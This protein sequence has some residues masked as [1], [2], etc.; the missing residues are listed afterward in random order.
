MKLQIEKMV[1]G[2]AGLAYPADGAGAGKAVFVAFALPGEVVEVQLADETSGHGDAAL[3]QVIEASPDRVEAVCAHFGACGGCQYQ[4]ADYAAQLAMKAG[5][6]REMLERAGVSALPEV[7]VHAGEA[8]GY[9]NR[10]RLRVAKVEGRLRV[11]YSRR[12]GD[13]FL[14]IEECP[15]AAPVLWRAAKAFLQ[16]AETD[17]AAERWIR[18]AVEVEFF[19]SADESRLQMTVLVRKGLKYGFAGLCQ[20]LKKLVPELVGAGV[21]VLGAEVAQRG[22]RMERPKVGEGWGAAGLMYGAAGREYW[23]SRG[24]FFQVNRFLVDEMVRVVTEGR[25]G[26]IAW[27]LYAGVGLFARAL[28]E[29]FE[30][31]VAVEGSPVAAGDLANSF[32]VKGMRAVCASTVEFLR[33]AVVQRERPEL[34][35]MD[36]PRA[37]VGTE[38]C[39]LLARVKAATMVYVSCDPVTLARDLK[40]LVDS[41]YRVVEVHL[42]DMFPQ[43]FHLESVVFLER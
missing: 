13:A 6:L 17:A 19:T 16:L 33:G 22:R 27:D 31:V 3:V 38:V 23:V 28:A 41:G 37:G 11:G 4:H 36:P 5:I 8:W 34:V 40:M 24:G 14:A 30:Q 26:L 2:G 10:I 20:G 29:G 42:V 32:K 7:Q 9:R 35:V 12:S 39:A 1:Y 18:S 21:A 43:T 15:I 25:K